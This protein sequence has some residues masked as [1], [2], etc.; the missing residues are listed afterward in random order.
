M[1]RSVWIFGLLLI[2]MIG[3]VIA[4]DAPDLGIGGTD[5]DTITEA[6]KKL[7]PLNEEGELDIE[8]YKPFKS[9]AGERIDEI[10]LWLEENASWLSAV[11]GMVPVLSWL[12]A[13]NLYLILL[14]FVI[15]VLNGDAILDIFEVL[16]AKI[17]LVFFETHWSNIF[18]FGVFATLIVT[19]VFVLLAKF[20]H[21]IFEIFWNYILPAGIAIAIILLIIIIVLGGF[22]LIKFLPQ[23][24][25]VVRQAIK[26]RKEKKRA[27]KT[28][29]NEE[30]LEE[31][32]KGI[33]EA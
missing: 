11:F 2:L 4:Q 24:M 29:A 25:E 1:K 28:K 23:I 19:K 7:S 18:G 21:D 26:K 27:K 5:K 33:T 10:N 16:G 12:F 13:I 20:L 30:V 14:F 3:G 32:I 22:V 8:K 17:D 9:K 15:L 31:T 6:Q